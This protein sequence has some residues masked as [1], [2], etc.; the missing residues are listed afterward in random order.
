MEPARNEEHRPP[1]YDRNSVL[2]F[3]LRADRRDYRRRLS[4]KRAERRVGEHLVEMKETRGEARRPRQSE[5]GIA[6]RYPEAIVSSSTLPVRILATRIV[7]DTVS[8]G[9]FNL[10]GCDA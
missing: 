10:R 2:D 8:A 6:S 4:L 1:S 3:C 9:R 5:N 7:L